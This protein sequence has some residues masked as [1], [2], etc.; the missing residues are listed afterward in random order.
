MAEVEGNRERI[1]DEENQHWWWEFP[2]LNV[3]YLPW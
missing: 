2:S 3:I 1:E